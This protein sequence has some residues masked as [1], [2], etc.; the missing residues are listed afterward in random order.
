MAKS[1]SRRQEPTIMALGPNRSRCT[2]QQRLVHALFQA[3]W[4]DSLSQISSWWQMGATRSFPLGYSSTLRACTQNWAMAIDLFETSLAS[5]QSPQLSA[6][7]AAITC[8]NPK[9]FRWQ[10]A[11]HVM[12]RM[13][14]WQI[15]PSAISFNSILSVCEKLGLK[16]STSFFGFHPLL[17]KFSN[18][19]ILSG[20]NFQET[21][22]FPAQ[23]HSS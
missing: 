19:I 6:F 16:V 5:K 11:F 13:K 20:T 9:V 3:A 15:Q 14:D 2:S 1:G 10:S 12:E 4:Q 22:G 18:M 7:N 21:F 17:G 23:R 8:G